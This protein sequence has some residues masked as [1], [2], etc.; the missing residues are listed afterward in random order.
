MPADAQPRPHR[1]RQRRLRG[2]LGRA[3]SSPRALGPAGPSQAAG[4]KA[5]NRAGSASREAA[6]RSEQ[7]CPAG[8]DEGSAAP[9]PIALP[10]A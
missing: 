10:P 7:G 1:P 9:Y 6:A 5:R 3:V 2:A 4:R 8:E